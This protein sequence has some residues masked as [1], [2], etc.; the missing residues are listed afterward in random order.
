MPL[1]QAAFANA[2][3]I[4]IAVLGLTSVSLPSS[5][6]QTHEE[7]V[8]IDEH[9]LTPPISAGPFA[10]WWWPGT[11]VDPLLLS[12]DLRTLSEAGFAGGY[13]F[14]SLAG[15]GWIR[16]D[17][18]G[19]ARANRF[20]TPEYYAL[21]ADAVAEAGA[22]G[23]QIDLLAGSGWPLGGTHVAPEDS[24]QTLAM[25]VLPLEGGTPFSGEVP[26]WDRN[27]FTRSD[28]FFGD[29]AYAFE[30]DLDL[31]GVGAARVIQTRPRDPLPAL[32]ALTENPQDL[33]IGEPPW[34]A[35]ILLDPESV[36]DLSDQVTSGGRL[37]WDVP[38]GDWYLFAYYGGPIG[39]IPVFDS[40]DGS[41]RAALVLDHLAREPIQ[42]HIDHVIGRAI[43][44]IGDQFGN[45]IRSINSPSVELKSDWLWTET[46]LDEFEARRG[47][48]LM[49]FLMSTYVPGRDNFVANLRFGDAPPL[50]DFAADD[51]GDRVRYDYM[52]TVSDL[53][54]ENYLDGFAEWADEHGLQTH[55]QTF[56]LPVDTIRS[57]EY[58]DMPDTEALYAGGTMDFL[59]LTGSAAA[60]HGRRISS[61]EFLTWMSRDYMTSPLKIKVHADRFFVSGITQL[62][63]HSMYYQAPEA[64]Y[65]GFNAWSHP[66]MP[67]SF[68]GSMT[69]ANP[70][71]DYVPELNGYISRNQVIA[72]SGRNMANIGILHNIWRYPGG[73]LRQEETVNGYLG[74]GDVPPPIG[75]PPSFADLSTDEQHIYQRVETGDALAA[76]G[77]DYVLVNTDSLMHGEMRDGVLHMGDIRMEALVLSNETHIPAELARR[78]TELSVNGFEV[79]FVGAT[80]DR[81]SGFQDHRTNDAVVRAMV[82]TL[83][84][85]PQRVDNAQTLP[86]QLRE[87]GIEPGL[88]FESEEPE[89]QYIRR[90]IN[91][92]RFYFIRSG[93]E[94]H[95]SFSVELPCDD[96]CAPRYVDLWTGVQTHA[97][98]YRRSAD[99]VTLP[100]AFD[101]FGSAMIRLGPPASGRH[102]AEGDLAVRRIGTHLVVEAA[103]SGTYDF[104]YGNGDTAEIEVVSLPPTIE[105]EDWTLR[106]LSRSPDGATAP[107]EL[108]LDALADWRD[109][110]QL[111]HEAGRAV[112]TSSFDLAA[113]HLQNELR[114]ILDLGHVHEVA[115]VTVNGRRTGHMLIPP[116]QI[117]VTDFVEPGQNTIEIAVTPVLYN[118][119]V[120]YGET[121]DARWRHFR[122]R[123]G[124]APTGLIGPVRLIPYWQER[125]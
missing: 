90:Q 19:A 113:T 119:L 61:G 111:R 117:D 14:T 75:F 56:G 95:R 122:N 73:A 13:H 74:S 18:E 23:L 1:R 42:A 68:A 81:H 35:P 46:F 49:P 6:Q 82:E 105:L 27:H 34:T 20:A 110:P 100:L 80:P 85:G 40:R 107:I 88:S 22:R 52:H 116:Y 44:Y 33:F 38:P 41:P 32:S 30:P 15:V 24:S 104:T 58:V 29:I 70:I 78:L 71:F 65:P 54:I 121:G 109:I 106:T 120:G 86:A 99:T 3:Y 57:A 94:A 125:L 51:V 103:E 11:D 64:P 67:V 39:E 10:Y 26:H 28:W 59:R 72:Q 77:Y 16:E 118:R 84:T 66:D 25:G 48:D 114:L 47:Y 31:V 79:F 45:T 102:V 89:I 93:D 2:T 83:A 53:F 124:L 108:R 96:T 8:S 76:A 12:E 91:E 101:A 123:N 98:M 17:A 21:L 7:E 97:P 36:I 87:V 55:S 9:L 43:P 63:Y 62:H 37:D 69:R 4:V 92:D 60:L 115:E 50:F 5:A 112:Y